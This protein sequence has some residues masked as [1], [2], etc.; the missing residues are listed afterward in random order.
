MASRTISKLRMLKQHLFYGNIKS[1]QEKY[2][3][4]PVNMCII[5]IMVL[6]KLKRRTDV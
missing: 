4:S 2:N 1:C 6:L 5:N 3:E